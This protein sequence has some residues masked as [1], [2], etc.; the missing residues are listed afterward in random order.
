MKV[1]SDPIKSQNHIRESSDPHDTLAILD[2][3][4]QFNTANVQ[5]Q[6]EV[7]K[8]P[9]TQLHMEE[10]ND[11]MGQNQNGVNN[12]LANDDSIQTENYNPE[13]QILLEKEFVALYQSKFFRSFMGMTMFFVHH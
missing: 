11:S 6:N 7:N 1:E 13:I 8:Y 5:E 4:D 12:N 10:Y 3:L 9:A 2:Y